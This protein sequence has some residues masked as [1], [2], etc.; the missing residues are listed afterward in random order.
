MY[1]LN[2]MNLSLLNHLIKHEKIILNAEYLYDKK[3]II[4]ILINHY[5]NKKINLI[6]V[7]D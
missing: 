2:K 6:L 3:N 1:Y 7:I 5:N 4:E